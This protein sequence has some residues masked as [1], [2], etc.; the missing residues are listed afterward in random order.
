MYRFPAPARV[1]AAAAALLL[2]ACT[3]SNPVG[4]VNLPPVETLAALTCTVE[5]SAGTMRC[6]RTPT[7]ASAARLDKIYGGQDTYVQLASSGTSYDSGT[8]ILSSNVTVENLLNQ[9]IGT[10]DGSTVAG[11]TV[12]FHAGPT[13]T[14]GSGTAA[15][16][17][18]DG[19]GTFTASNQPYFLYSQI[20]ETYE[21]SAPRT[22]Q[23]AVQTTVTTFTFQVYISA[24]MANE[25]TG[26]PQML[27]EYWD[28]SASSDWHTAANWAD[29][30]VPDS[31]SGVFI[32]AGTPNAPVMAADADILHL[33]VATSATLSQGGFTLRV[34]GNVDAQGTI[35]NG[36]LYMSGSGAVLRGNTDDLRVTGSTS[37]QGSTRATGAVNIS[38]GS[39]T[40]KDQAISISL[41]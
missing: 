26:V 13:V 6:A 38:D 8:E 7:T 9:A 35:S 12:F 30:T 40:V 23:F 36:T 17:N 14:G 33:R 4:P 18:A 28:G 11:V 34:R 19:M 41:P 24:P 22:W 32:P 20:V 3:D 37:L 31:S 39:L 16:A 27:N 21:L 29:G 2:A 5:V 10:P 15:V 1:G 25:G